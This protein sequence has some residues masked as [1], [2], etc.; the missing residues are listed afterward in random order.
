MSRADAESLD[1][2]E[3]LKAGTGKSPVYT[4]EL[5][6]VTSYEGETMRVEVYAPSRTRTLVQDPC[7]DRYRA[8]LVAGAVENNLDPKWITKLKNLPVYE[9]SAETLAARKALPSPGEMPVMTIAELA[10]HNGKSA[11]HPCMTSVC[12]Y[13]FQIKVPFV[14]MRG[15]DVTYRN[16]IHR[17]GLS[18]SKHDDGGVSPFPRL[19][20]M[21]P[22]ERE[23]ALRYRDF[24]TAKCK[25]PVAVL[26]EFWEE[27]E[28]EVE[29]L[30]SGNTLSKL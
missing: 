13:I 20:Q 22:E 3:G 26:K 8:I 14:A 25:K 2:Q 1:R 4:L 18:A 23:Y 6:D 10:P 29:G 30:F 27:Q 9:P 5:V 21:A 15:R 19:S 16:A 7:S 12:G 24:F 28:T 11:D 17:R